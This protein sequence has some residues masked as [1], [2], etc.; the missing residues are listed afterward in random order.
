M[1][2][3]QEFIK[4]CEKNCN[5]VQRK[6]FKKDEIITTYIAKRNQICILISGSA[7]L[8]RYDSNGNK[9]IVE[10]FTSND[11]FGE[12]FYTIATNNELFV[13][14][15]HNSEVLFFSYDLMKHKCK[16]NC[17]FHKIFQDNL[18]KLILSKVTM[19]NTRVELLTKRSIRDKLLGYFSILSVRNFNRT[20]SLPFSLTDL[21][22]YLSIDRSAMM[23][24]LK[25]LKDDGII[26]KNGNKITLLI[27]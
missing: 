7:D 27:Q 25:Y 1:I 15:R 3:F 10:H 23:R 20:F 19:L 24:E 13:K 11:I 8:V 14:A 12:I 9:T 26:K 16:T 22:D 4:D 6:S 21:A 5:K 17:A 18:S 2:S